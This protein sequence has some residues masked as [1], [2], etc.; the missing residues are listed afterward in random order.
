M[1]FLKRF[2]SIAK[3]GAEAGDIHEAVKY[4]IEYN[5]DKN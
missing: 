3:S 5:G 4:A 1:N 2:M